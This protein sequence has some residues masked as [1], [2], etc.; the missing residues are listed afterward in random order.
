MAVTAVLRLG[1]MLAAL[2]AGA[3]DPGLQ[4][5]TMAHVRTL[6][7]L[8]NRVAGSE[9]ESK[10]ARYV[11]DQM[12]RA[13]LSV[14]V[15]PF[16]FDAFTLSSAVLEAGDD[17]AEIVRLGFNP[18]TD[19]GRGGE[20]AF[21]ESTQNMSAV[22]KLDLDGKIVVTTGAA[23]LYALSIFKDPRA[24]VALTRAD[25][26]RIGASGARIGKIVARGTTART[27]SANIVGTLAGGAGQEIV[28]SAH[29]DSWKGP[30]ANDNASGVAVLLELARRYGSRKPAPAVTL[31]FVAF[32]AEELGLL[33]AKAYLE[34]HQRELENCR[35]LFNID[36][37]GGDGK[38]V[39]DTRWGVRGVP[40][41]VGSQLPKEFTGKATVDLDARWMLLSTGLRPLFMS[42]NVPMWL[43]AAVSE[44]GKELG[45][46]FVSSGGAG[47][48][49]RVFVQAGVVATNIAISGAGIHTPADVAASVHADSLEMAARVVSTVVDTILRAP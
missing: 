1:T 12:E 13:G 47:S 48:D 8:G 33:G 26:E 4:E 27:N 22:M 7:A 49:H 24:A 3:Q 18:Y 46:E 44:A 21:L 10:A 17:K 31:R 23:N 42:S 41:K 34:K 30:G 2:A 45:R 9:G 28:L 32:G 16:A 5:R 20:L 43:S 40:A 15:E 6:A 14:A 25:F 36:T 11:Q 39:A 35:M 38:V 29:Y 19:D 37:V